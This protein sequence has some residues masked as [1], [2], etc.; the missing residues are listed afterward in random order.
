M[1][2]GV[3]DGEF[4]AAAPLCFAGRR[5]VLS[6]E[7]HP[8]GFAEDAGRLALCVVVDLAT[9]GGGGCAGDAGGGECC[10]VGDGDVP[11]DADEDGG[12]ARCHG[13]KI[14]SR[15]KCLV[16]PQ[17]VIPAAPR[18]PVA[19]WCCDCGELN[20]PL[21]FGERG[22]SGEVNLQ[23]D[24]AG[25]TEMH[26]GIVEA[27]HDEGAVEINLAGGGTGEGH[28][29]LIIA[30]DD[31][32]TVANDERSREVVNEGCRSRIAGFR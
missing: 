1:G 7:V 17:S 27:G 10:R 19:L 25:V 8:R 4:E 21:H 28:R 20:T 30:D 3:G 15:G 6:D 14:C 9:W 29:G 23:F 13:V 22:A 2:D 5:N 31:H 18:E 24:H 12:M 32:F 11:V 26:M 16:C